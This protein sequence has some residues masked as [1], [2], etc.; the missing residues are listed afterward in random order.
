MASRKR[1]DVDTFDERWSAIGALA[2][3][4]II[5]AFGNITDSIPNSSS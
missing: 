2:L 3:Y 1:G 5:V 4:M